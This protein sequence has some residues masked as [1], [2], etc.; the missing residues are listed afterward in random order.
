MI[1]V[2]LVDDE[3]VV[4]A[5]VRAILASDAEIEVVAE[6]GDGRQA[7]ELAREHRP[8]V[9]LLDIRM[10]E[11]DG[12]TAGAEIRRV[13][14]ETA[15]VMLT[16]FSEDSYIARALSDGASGF[17]LKSGDPRE[18]VAGVR[19]VA[20]GAA[21]LSPKVAHRVITELSVGDPGGRMSRRSAALE[22][23]E[24]LAERERAVLALVGQGLSNAEIA[25]RLHVVEGTVKSYVS[26]VLSRL[27]VR[28]RVEA[29]ILAHEA[30]IVN[31]SG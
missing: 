28:N 8:D 2:L 11:L 24:P 13:V 30:G 6:A 9:V 4:R 16:T 18:L 26:T 21:F 27:D 19:A 10:P 20:D 25:T 17:L 5:G 3:A 23:I 22:R 31:R 12:L 1:R 7:V 15:V 29:A 14:P